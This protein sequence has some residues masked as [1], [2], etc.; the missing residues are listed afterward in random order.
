MKEAQAPNKDPFLSPASHQFEVEVLLLEEVA[1]VVS[2]EREGCNF[3]L[4]G[5]HIGVTPIELFFVMS[6]L[7][8][9]QRKLSELKQHAH[10][11]R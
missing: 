11:Y 8:K 5:A 4:V 10:G 7:K 2:R 1:Q 6:T 3:E 9:L